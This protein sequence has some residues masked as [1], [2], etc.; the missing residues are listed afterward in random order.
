MKRIHFTNY[1]VFSSRTETKEADSI[2]HGFL[3][4]SCCMRCSLAV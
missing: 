1:W 4:I 3:E 2:R